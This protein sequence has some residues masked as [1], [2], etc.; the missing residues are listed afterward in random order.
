MFQGG[1]DD[2]VRGRKQAEDGRRERVGRVIGEAHA[3][4]VV[5]SEQRRELGA[6]AKDCAP[7][8]ERERMAAAPGEPSVSNACK[9]AA[10]TAGGFK[11]EVAAASK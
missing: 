3:G 1:R 2:M 9:T 11:K 7:G 5:Q 4:G 8:C 10:L 6:A